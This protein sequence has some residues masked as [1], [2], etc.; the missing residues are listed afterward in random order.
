MTGSRL[1]RCSWADNDALRPYHDEEWGV[2][3]HDES[4]LFELLTL[5]GAQAGLSWQ[6]VLMRR[7]GYR[8]A[9]VD[10]DA[11]RVARFNDGDVERLLSD[12]SIIRHRGKIES[13]IANAAAILE[14]N[15][16]GESL[17]SVLWSFVEG[18][19]RQHD[20]SREP[21]LPAF[22]TESKNMSSQLQKLGFRFVGPTTSY[23]LMQAAGLV[24]DHH[25]ECFRFEEVRSLSA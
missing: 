25:V 9:F 23:A 15:R 20:W 18:R 13:T 2:P 12:S 4:G 8:R 3:L 19:A 11:Q 16:S 5:E 7:D 6:T 1:T 10:F 14:L 24:N 22:S 17:D 21:R